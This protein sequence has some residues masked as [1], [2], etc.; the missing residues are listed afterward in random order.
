MVDPD[1][2]LDGLDALWPAAEPRPDFVARVTA[3]IGEAGGGRA[4]T[5]PRR[6]MVPALAGVAAVAIACSVVLW[7]TRPGAPAA[8]P[9]APLQGSLTAAAHETISLGDR[10]VIVAHP[11]AVLTWSIGAGGDA[12]IQQIAGEAFFRVE[13]GGRF[14]VRTPSG[15]VRVT[16]TCFTVAVSAGV[17][18]V[19][20]HEG[21]VELADA[22]SAV[23]LRPGDRGH[24]GGAAAARRRPAPRPDVVAGRIAPLERTPPRT[25]ARGDDCF[26][27]SDPRHLEA[28]Q[29]LLDEWAGL[30]RVRADVPPF[31]LSGG[32]EAIDAA[33]DQ[34]GLADAERVAFRD[35]ALELTTD[36]IA[37]LR[38]MYV[39][40]TGDADGAAA[41]DPDAMV[42]QILQTGT[43]GEDARLRAT[44]SQERAGH[45]APPTD[46]DAMTPFEEMFRA[47]IA[48]G[49][50]FERRLAARLGAAR[51]R[52]L[53]ARFG[54]W[55]G[56]DF[57]WFGCPE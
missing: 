45:A 55:P 36:A 27:F 47:T 34:L 11:G 35:A 3:R 9:H 40:A 41:V 37:S 33:S 14:V 16:G 13:P 39:A 5:P 7:I 51:A 10:G 2:R 32:L 29:R 15:E 53:R 30:C 8:P 54:G 46:R 6:W 28:D 4:P 19:D 25:E 42:E 50:D 12:E 57:D 31:G 48:T 38:E 18:T 23:A 24:L 21:S 22:T 49:D 44:L 43:L 1:E 26:C 20:V 56:P 52:E 17:V